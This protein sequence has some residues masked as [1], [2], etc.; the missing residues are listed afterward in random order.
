MRLLEGLFGTAVVTV[1]KRIETISDALYPE[2]AAHVKDAA[3]RRRWEF[4]AGRVCARE[5]LAGLGIRGFPLLVAGDRTPIWPPGVL[6]SISHAAGH[7][8]VAVAWR[9]QV[10]GL[11]LDIDSSTDL[12]EELWPTILTD[13][14]LLWLQTQPR[15]TR[16]KLAKLFF[17]AKECTYKCQHSAF[18]RWMDFHDVIVQPH[19]G[20][21]VFEASFLGDHP[22]LRAQRGT[23]RGRFAFGDGLVVTGMEWRVPAGGGAA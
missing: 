5:A 2:E 14:E 19:L 18:G 15:A 8:G 21:G 17:S 7:C 22:L 23:V 4:V 10:T 11:G 3:P 13:S 20:T 6:G 12:N 1:A 9:S 16:A